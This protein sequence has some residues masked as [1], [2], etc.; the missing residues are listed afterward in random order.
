MSQHLGTL[1]SD[2][3]VCLSC[4][5]IGTGFLVDFH[6]SL[7]VRSAALNLRPNLK[8]FTVQCY[9]I[10]VG[11]HSMLGFLDVNGLATEASASDNDIP[12]CAVFKAPQSLAP[13][14]HIPT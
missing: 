6:Q 3:H 14:P 1:H 8:C 5:S 9:L 2:K 13:S 10:T 7:L 12:V 4:N 11:T